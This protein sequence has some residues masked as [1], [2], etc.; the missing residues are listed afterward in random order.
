MSGASRADAETIEVLAPAKVNLWL[1]LLGRRPDGYHLIDSLVVFAEI[2]DSLVVTPADELTL[3]VDGPFARA[4]PK[5]SDNLVLRA[6]RLLAEAGCVAP[7]ARL[8]L[9]KRLPVAAGIGGGSADAAATFRALDR[10]WRLGLDG[11]SLQKLALELGADVPVCLAGEPCHVGGIGEILTPAPRLPAV[12][13]VLVN[14]GVAL[15]TARVFAARAGEF[16]PD[17]FTGRRPDPPADATALAAWLAGWRNDLTEA[18]ASLSPAI[19]ET[20]AILADQ[21]GCLL[22][23]MSGSG[24]TCFGLFADEA[25]AVAAAAAIEERRPHWWVSKT[26]LRG[27]KH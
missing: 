16:L 6:A 17:P 5:E 24:A 14:A 10:L 11:S 27:S 21:P 15:D 25:D 19:G 4:L 23:R 13:A 1:H 22:S 18:A 26:R 7:Q 9:T 12:H 20:L 3:E 2:G 8:R